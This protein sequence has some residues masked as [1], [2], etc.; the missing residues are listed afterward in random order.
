MGGERT[1][2]MDQTDARHDSLDRDN[3]DGAVPEADLLEQERGALDDDI[4]PEAPSPGER[5]SVDSTE[6]NEADVLEQ[7]VDVTMDDDSDSRDAGSY[8]TS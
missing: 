6:A 7:S 3:L 8:S 2:P 1:E 5:R 4:D